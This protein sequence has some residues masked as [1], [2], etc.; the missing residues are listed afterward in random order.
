VAGGESGLPDEPPG[1]ASGQ[2]MSDRPHAVVFGARSLVGPHLLTRLADRGFGGLC[3]TR[4]RE[5]G[6]LPCPAGFSVGV[7]SEDQDL[8]IPASAILFSL[9]PIPALPA[10][11]PR[12]AG[13]SRLIAVSTSSAA[14]KAGSSDAGDRRLAEEVCRAETAVR[15]LCGDRGIACTIFRP[16]LVYDPGRDGNVSAIAAFVQRFGAFPII[17]PGTGLRQPI[18]A[19]DVAQALLA[20][21]ASP[22]TAGNVYDLPGGETLAYKDMV[23]RIFGAL[24]RRPLLLPLPL[25]LA[26]PAFHAWKALSGADY[27]VASLERMNMDLAL[28]PTPARQA[29]GVTARPFRPEFPDRRRIGRG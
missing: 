23:R 6:S 29:L 10:L 27:S 25:G 9:I 14:F 8:A 18:H 1:V 5:P 7:V 15:S 13:G 24:G 19:D 22:E 17:L 4:R 28:D 2:P 11:L 16:T 12:T 21:A 3:L 26:R 20:A